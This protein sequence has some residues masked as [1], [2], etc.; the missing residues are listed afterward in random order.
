[1]GYGISI[2]M[3]PHKLTSAKPQAGRNKPFMYIVVPTFK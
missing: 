2:L 3:A 1:M